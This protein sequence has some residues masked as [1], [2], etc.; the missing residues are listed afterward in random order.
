MNR[1]FI[2]DC[3]WIVSSQQNKTKIMSLNAGDTVMEE[4][5]SSVNINYKHGGIN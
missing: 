4:I 5:P 3:I 1:S 2:T